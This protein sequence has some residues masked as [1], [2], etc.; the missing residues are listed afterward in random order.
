MQGKSYNSPEFT[1]I[2]ASF[3]RLSRWE[4]WGEVSSA[5][6]LSWLAIRCGLLV[7]L[8]EMP[9]ISTGPI[10]QMRWGVVSLCC[11]FQ[12]TG[13]NCLHQFNVEICKKKSCHVTPGFVVG[14]FVV[15]FRSKFS[16]GCLFPVNSR[17][18]FAGNS[19][20]HRKF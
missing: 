8:M 7:A 9:V 12:E 20:S 10:E 3:L 5:I 6:L 11:G 2:L 15:F 18:L 16:P 1:E 13:G 14:I 19:R 17:T 4:G